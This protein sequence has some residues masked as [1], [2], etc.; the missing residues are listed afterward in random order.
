MGD[1]LG[2]RMGIVLASVHDGGI[3]WMIEKLNMA[4]RAL[5]D[6]IHIFIIDTSHQLGRFTL[7]KI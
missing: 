7:K 5:M 4:V 6:F 2:F 3:L 1:L